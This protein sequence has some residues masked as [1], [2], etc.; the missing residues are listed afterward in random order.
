MF[1][2]SFLLAFTAGVLAFL[3]P[4]VLPIIPGYLSYISGMG[5]QEVKE[6]GRGVSWRI[7]FASVLF[8][9]GFSLVFTALG[10]GASAIGRVLRDYQTLIA[11]LGGAVVVFFGLHFSGVFLRQNFLKEA[12]GV[13]SLVVGLY[14]L[15]FM[16]QK[17]FFDIAGILLV[18]TFL[19]LFGVHE[20][21]YRQT[22][23]ESKSG[24]PMLGAFLVGVFFAFGWSPCIGPVLGSILLYASQQ[25]TVAKGAML[26]F[27][28]SM[29]LGLPFI[30]AGALL[31]AFLGFVKKF[32][33][34]FGVVELV[35]GVLL[36]IL[37]VLLTTGKL[38]EISALL[39]V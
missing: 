39:G 30:L 35:G 33:K 25:E 7:L 22:R 13:A 38:S 21:L 19:Y 37:G 24:L 5:A 12:L 31:S 3:S 10:A 14:F 28:F 23:K 2:V 9:L 34:F 6:Q 27:V 20:L 17:V 16:S 32:S 11:K 29:G 18:C 36:V 4:C 8:V 26:L 15:G 1:E